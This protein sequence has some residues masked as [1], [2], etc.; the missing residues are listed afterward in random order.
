MKTR[1]EKAFEQLSDADLHKKPSS[2]SNNIAIIMQHFSGNMR[3]RW[4]DFLEA[5]GEKAS[6]DR[7][8]E[9]IDQLYTRDFLNKEWNKGWKLLFNTIE[10]LHPGDLLRSVSLRNKPLSVMSAV[11]I[12]AAHISYHVGQIIY[13]GKLIKDKDWV[14]L[15]IPKEKNY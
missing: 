14:T 13:I 8:K 7:E 1:A 5:D 11:Q 2:E 12:E 6:R 9:F 10:T 4:V 15:S 3:S